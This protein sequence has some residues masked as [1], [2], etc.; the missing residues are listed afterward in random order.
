MKAAVCSFK[1][2]HKHKNLDAWV[3]HFEATLNVLVAA[4]DVILFP[5]LLWLDLLRYLPNQKLE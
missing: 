1:L 3:D 5:E 4:H 2:S